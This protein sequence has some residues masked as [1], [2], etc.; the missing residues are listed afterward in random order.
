MTSEKPG[1]VAAITLSFWMLKVIATTAGDLTGDA[2]SISLG[3]GYLLALIVALAVTA[4]LLFAQL[5]AKRFHPGLYWTLI[6]A[7]SAAGAE[8]SDSIDRA[9]HWGTL[10]GT[11]ALLVGLLLALAI[12]RARRGAIRC[13]AIEDPRDERFYWLAAILANSFG[14]AV[15]DLIGEKLGVGVLGGAAVNAGILALLVLLHY[16][17]RARKELLFWSAFVFT[18]IP[19]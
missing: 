5:K 17:T 3:L 2:L 7:S 10:A 8:I 13:K 14:S 6:L 18:R 1:K 9:L 15:C 19:F 16:T 12:W 4:A 11:G